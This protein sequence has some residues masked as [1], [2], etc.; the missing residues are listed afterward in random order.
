VNGFELTER[1]KKDPKTARVP[2]ILVTSLGSSEDKTRGIEAGADAYIVKS[3]FD[4][5]NLLETIEQLI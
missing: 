1:I 3:T 4:Q 5:S 2:V